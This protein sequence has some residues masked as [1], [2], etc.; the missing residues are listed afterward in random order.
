MR[1]FS[2]R[3]PLK[4]FFLAMS[5]LMFLMCVAFLG[6]GIKELIE[7]GLISA[8]NLGWFQ[9]NEILNILGIYPIAQTLFPQIALVMIGVVTFIIQMR[10]NRKIAAENEDEASGEDK[11][12][13][14]PSEGISEA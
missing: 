11:Q 7:G 12:E 10:R 1:F 14:P 2:V 8:T 13:T 6:S 3:L 4:P 9:Q 5:F